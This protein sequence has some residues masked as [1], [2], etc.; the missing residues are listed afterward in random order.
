MKNCSVVK[1]PMYPVIRVG[2]G[3]VQ[4][5][6]VQNQLSRL[7]W[8]YS[9]PFIFVWYGSI[10]DQKYVTLTHLTPEHFAVCVQSIKIFF[11]PYILKSRLVQGLNKENEPKLV[12]QVIFSLM[13][14]YKDFSLVCLLTCC[15]QISCLPYHILTVALLIHILGLAQPIFSELIC[16]L[17]KIYLIKTNDNHKQLIQLVSIQYSAGYLM[18]N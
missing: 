4:V 9:H 7:D 18:L 8:P 6:V 5:R 11:E 12:S 15:N 16:Q 3:W 10:H 17:L 13:L 2:L 1:S 14:N